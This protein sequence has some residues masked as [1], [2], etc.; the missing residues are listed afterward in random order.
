MDAPFASRLGIAVALGIAVLGVLWFRSPETSDE[1]AVV[2]DAAATVVGTGLTVHVSGEVAE[3]GLVALASG[4]RVA[5]AVAAAG[6]TLPTADLGAVNLAAPVRDGEHIT[7]GSVVDA[8]S[9]QATD[10]GFVHVN[11]AGVVE[12]QALP[13]VGPV[14]AER[15]AAY[16]DQHG[17]YTAVEDLLDVPGIG[18]AKLAGLR[19]VVAIP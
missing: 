2:S 9:D 14:L 18:E 3:P 10:D 8:D 11:E 7:I 12:L 19:D 6:G 16:R 17:P 5:D 1:V 4:S 13:G 15:I